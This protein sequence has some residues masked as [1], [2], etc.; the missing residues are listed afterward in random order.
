M[1]PVLRLIDHV[2][3]FAMA[4]FF[5]LALIVGFGTVVARYVF[6]TGV[7]WSDQ[8]FVKFT[9]WAA[10]FGASRAVRDGLHV[11]VDLI[12]DKLSPAARRPVEMLGLVIN[13]AFCGAMLWAAIGYTDFLMMVGTTNIDTGLPE[14]IA[15]LV[16]PAFLALMCV[17]YLSLIPVAS[18]SLSGDPWKPDAAP[19]ERAPP[20]PSAH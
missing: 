13:I 9:I 15:F 20:T 4:F 1:R 3:T 16:T 11:R 10:L 6:N 2:E 7:I 19:G 17:R 8:A 12:L 18:R 14:W 5:T